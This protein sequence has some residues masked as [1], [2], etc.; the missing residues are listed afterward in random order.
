M[1]IRDVAKRAGVCL[2]TASR[3]MNGHASV[4]P[5]KKKKVL[6]AARELKYT[7]NL[8]ARGLA[9]NSAD[10]VSILV[11]KLYNPYFGLLTEKL[12]LNLNKHGISS[13]LCDSPE[14]NGELVR[15]LSTRGTFMI[16]N[17]DAGLIREM[18]SKHPTVGINCV[19]PDG[20]DMTSVEIDF[21]GAYA[22]LANTAL[23]AGKRNIAF[24]SPILPKYQ[25]MK[26]QAVKDILAR[27]RIK[28][29]SPLNSESF[30]NVDE[31]VALLLSDNSS[32]DMVF[33]ENDLLASVLV[34]SM[35]ANRKRLKKEPV[36]VGCDNTIPLERVWTV[37]VDIDAIADRAVDAYMKVSKGGGSHSKITVM[38]EP[39][40]RN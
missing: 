5:D 23:K 25:K 2:V 22:S 6:D 3:A 11:S 27:Q 29:V 9:G 37:D 36:V 33:C 28:P 20:V 17:V 14:K 30:Q 35:H 24:L 4:R 19:I 13:I 32:V 12:S 10:L 18:A 26:F 38:A 1:T 8:L 39:V 16:S 40:I 21:T 34:A 7:P 15:S 31:L